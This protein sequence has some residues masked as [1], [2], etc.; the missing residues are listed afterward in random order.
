M[1]MLFLLLQVFLW[2][3]LVEKMFLLAVQSHFSRAAHAGVEPNEDDL[4]LCQRIGCICRFQRTVGKYPLHAVLILFCVFFLKVY[5]YC[6]C[7][8]SQWF[9]FASSDSKQLDKQLHCWNIVSESV[10]LWCLSAVPH[11][12]INKVKLPTQKCS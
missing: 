10:M 11:C 8:L 9:T 2:F 5:H 1:V 3:W 12:F 6:E 4:N 7:A